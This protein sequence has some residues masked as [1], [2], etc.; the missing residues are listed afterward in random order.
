MG[1][2]ICSWV[3]LL[4]WSKSPH[5]LRRWYARDVNQR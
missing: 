5:N 3:G 4:K 2:T 1:M